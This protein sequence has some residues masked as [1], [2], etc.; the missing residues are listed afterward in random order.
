[1][2]KVWLTPKE[3]KS[4]LLLSN[5]KGGIIHVM[6][7]ILFVW[8][9]SSL[10]LF[11]N[12]A[13]NPKKTSTSNIQT[14][15]TIIAQTLKVIKISITGNIQTPTDIIVNSLVSKIGE[16]LITE[17]VI[18]DLQMI[19]QLSTVTDVNADTQQM[20]DHEIELIFTIQEPVAIRAW[21]IKGMTVFKIDQ[22]IPS[23]NLAIGVT[24]TNARIREVLEALAAFYRD[25]GYVLMRAIDIQNPTAEDPRVIIS[26]A[27]GEIEDIFISGNYKTKTYVIMRELS[28]QPGSVFN[29]NTMKDDYRNLVNLNYF[30][31]VRFGNPSPGI[32]SK[33][34]VITVEVKEKR[35]GTLNFGGGYGQTDGWFGFTDLSADNVM[36]DGYS[37]GIKGQWGQRR[38]TYQ[39]KY[40]NP[41]F[42][43]DRTSMQFRLWRT[44]GIVD[45][46]QGLDAFRTGW[47]IT[48]G[49]YL[50]K[51][52]MGNVTFR[53][54]DVQPTSS[55]FIPNYL[56]RSIGGSLSYD[57][58]DFFLNPTQGENFSVGAKTSLIML[59]ATIE[60]L[61]V[62]VSL[63]KFWP[64][65]DKLVLAVRG[66]YD[67]AFGTIFD[68]ERYFM[69]GATTVRGY[70]DNNPIGRGDR[71]MMTNVELRW[72]LDPSLQLV[73]FY[74][75]GRIM[76]G[77][78]SSS[79]V[80][81]D[82]WRSG[83][84]AGIRL[85]TPLGPIRLDV[86]WGD[87]S[88]IWHFSMGQTF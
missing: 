15:T 40:F 23:L 16:E 84:G 64:V 88:P 20:S 59:G 86:G 58:R 12:A 82:R 8:I 78:S 13:L 35:F 37:L 2:R 27:E 17:N 56:V 26:I 45:D 77:N 22:L 87:G 34:A 9:I 3:I 44:D 29:I 61:K 24:A 31:D 62:N 33:K 47:D 55:V 19:S 18:K 4:N 42:W 43:P 10:F 51:H 63:S 41:W 85:L 11:G 21:E 73:A 67:D 28:S 83:M 39:F 36:G 70:P 69:G 75:I 7:K 46:G 72:L 76:K 30:D 53:N 32:D 66:S 81:D 14:S 60:F 68:T 5:Y 79:F 49:K 57:T 65:M 50:S 80:G 54:E 74:D 52:V 71:R 48:V 38:T 25:K 1:M 6:R